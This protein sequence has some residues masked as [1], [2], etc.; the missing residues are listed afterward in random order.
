MHCSFSLLALK[1][2]VVLVLVASKTMVVSYQRLPLHSVDQASVFRGLVHLSIG[3]LQ[4]STALISMRDLRSHVNSFI[5][6]KTCLTLHTRIQSC[7]ETIIF[8]R[9]GNSCV[10]DISLQPPFLLGF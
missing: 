6:C 1:I 2:L 4:G 3:D 5:V 8:Q 10:I 9:L 7:A